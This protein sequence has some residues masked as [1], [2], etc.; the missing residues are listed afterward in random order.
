LTAGR[1]PS[2]QQIEEALAKVL[3]SA[4][5]A[6]AER[7]ARLLRFIV[8]E[9]LQ[10]RAAELKE[11]VIGVQ[12]LGRNPGFDSKLDPI[13]RV[14]IS[15]L[16]TRIDLYYGSQGKEDELQI[17]LPKGTYAPVFAFRDAAGGPAPIPP[18]RWRGRI[19]TLVAAVALPIAAGIW[20]QTGR[21]RE[22]T[23]RLN[24][25]MAAPD[26]AT[27]HSIAIS[28]DGATVA[29]AAYADGESKLFV[30]RLD[31]FRATSIPGT[32]WATYPFWAPDNRT[33]GFFAR[34][35]LLAVDI[36]GGAPRVICDATLGR[37][38]TWNAM[39]E[40]VFAPNVSGPLY[41][42]PAAGGKPVRVT[43]LNTS[44]SDIVH[45][46][47]QFLPD[48]RRFVYLALSSNI[49]MSGIYV[50]STTS[51][52]PQRIVAAGSGG[53]TVGLNSGYLLFE[54]NGALTAQSFDVDRAAV[55]G[56]T[57]TIAQQVRFDPLTRYASVSA[58]SSGTVVFV[59][60]SPFDQELVWMNPGGAAPT[61][62]GGLGDLLSIRMSPGERYV[63]V[64]RNDEQSGRPVIG[65]LDVARG[66]T[67]P[68]DRQYVDWFP[69]WS[70]D[71]RTVA[72][73]R[74]QTTAP[75]MN[76]VSVPIAGG[77]PTLLHSFDRPVFPSDWSRDGAWI[78]Y[79][80]YTKNLRSAVW[81][82]PVHGGNPDGPIAMTGSEHNAGG[83]VFYP[84]SGGR[85]PPWL[86]YTS[87]ESGRDE[88][89][90]QSFPV[91]NRKIQVSPAGGN[92]PL[93]RADGK[94]LFYVDAKGRLMSIGVID[95][96]TMESSEPIPLL[97]LPAPHPAAPYFALN[98][99]PAANG[100]RFLVRRQSKPAEAEMM[101]VMTNWKP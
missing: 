68:L 42:V 35:K 72:F 97:T 41:R 92:R 99:A 36:L 40:I 38:G 45:W 32:E 96:Q 60:G 54:R 31:S 50:S 63:L 48:G 56:D 21:P 87:D 98:Y 43:T 30:R 59:S 64:N 57:V 78:A 49:A 89:Y 67:H 100:N 47:P 70:P 11:S 18:P 80:A 13:V 74:V 93:W 28:P 12:V 34:G 77:E 3:A 37:G 91:P 4:S 53:A 46:W 10:G 65:V 25:A 52:S 61:R 73:S 1:T 82:L 23:P 20:F 44:R 16:R 33:I 55:R 9:G 5:F 101:S 6:A 71:E 66:S 69:V 81:I 22:D 62:V 29:I 24:L 2:Q 27:L 26:G 83:A 86:A 58:S 75:Q 17:S 85:R 79:T 94:A 95:P 8:M 84:E 15:R 19:W 88:V 39:G 14:E 76:L 90:V 7:P 51:E